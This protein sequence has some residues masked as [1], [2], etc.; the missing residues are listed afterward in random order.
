[1]VLIVIHSLKR[2]VINGMMKS[3]MNHRKEQVFREKSKGQDVQCF[4]EKFVN[5]DFTN[6]FIL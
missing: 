6:L 5:K 4:F 1:M 3:E 2:V